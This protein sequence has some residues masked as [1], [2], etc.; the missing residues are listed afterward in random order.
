MIEITQEFK[1]TY[2][3]AS[4]GLL[5][6]NNVKNQKKNTEL[7]ARKRQIE[8]EIRKQFDGKDRQ[9][10][11]NL[12][13]NKAYD[14]YYKMFKKTYHIL[15]QLESIAFK[16]K[17]IPDVDCLVEAMFMA[18]IKNQFLTAGHDVDKLEL[19]IKVDVSHG[20]EKYIL[21]NG[22]EQVCTQGDMFMY[23]SKGVISSILNGPDSRT[24]IDG[25]TNHV[26]YIVYA[27]E[28]IEKESVKKHLEDIRDNISIISDNFTV[29]RLD[30]L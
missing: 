7:S 5:L 3:G 17:S 29:E 20:N 30:V 1:S 12:D 2:S 28:G 19:P 4:I 25:S 18:E 22:K 27:P 8:S 11:N 23:D 15:L 14:Q 21:M 10:L 9:Y 24:K 16:G 13:N 6:I 26:L